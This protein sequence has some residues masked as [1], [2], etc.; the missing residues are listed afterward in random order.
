AGWIHACA[1][2]SGGCEFPRTNLPE[3]RMQRLAGK[4]R[5]DGR[6]YAEQIGMRAAALLFLSPCRFTIIVIRQFGVRKEGIFA[7]SG[8]N[9]EP[10]LQNRIEFSAL[11]RT[12]AEAVLNTFY[13]EAN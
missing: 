9:L 12:H 8:G 7:R 5:R 11:R 4:L 1:G 6:R 10:P 3:N 2:F 13:A